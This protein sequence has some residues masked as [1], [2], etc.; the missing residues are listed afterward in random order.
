M[1]KCKQCGKELIPLEKSLTLK[2]INRGATQFYCKKCLAEKFC[3]TE[4][5][6]DE[7]AEQ[8]KAQGCSLFV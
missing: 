3:T 5:K 2:L 6:L 8:F 7:M 1:S 4:Q